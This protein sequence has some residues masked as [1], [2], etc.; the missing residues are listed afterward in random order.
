MSTRGKGVLVLP[1]DLADALWEGP[2]L[3]V[4]VVLRVRILRVAF[5]RDLRAVLREPARR[6]LVSVDQP[7]SHG[8]ILWW[9]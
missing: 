3:I 2:Q 6:V 4:A 9:I 1:V 7:C 8:L 5:A